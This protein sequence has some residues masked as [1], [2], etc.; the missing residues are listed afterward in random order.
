MRKILYF[1]YKTDNSSPDKATHTAE[2][3]GAWSVGVSFVCHFY[4]ILLGLS[5]NGLTD[6]TD[7]DFIPWHSLFS[8]TWHISFPVWV[9]AESHVDL[10]TL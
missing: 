2:S 5:P 6:A 4:V 9:W 3:P 1:L 7:M 8:G 10:D